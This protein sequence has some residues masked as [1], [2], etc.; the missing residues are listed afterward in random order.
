MDPWNTNGG[1]NTNDNHANRHNRSHTPPQN[2]QAQACGPNQAQRPPRPIRFD[3]NRFNEA[4]EAFFENARPPFA[5]LGSAGMPVPM[6]L[7]GYGYSAGGYLLAKYANPITRK[8]E[9]WGLDERDF[10]EGCLSPRC[11]NA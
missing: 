6:V 10:R 5:Q 8:I 4:A 7:T 1:G 11:F 3:I 2:G 9:S